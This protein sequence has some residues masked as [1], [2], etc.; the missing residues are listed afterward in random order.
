MLKKRI[1]SLVKVKYSKL[2]LGL[3]A[4]LLL[5]TYSYSTAQETHFE[6]FTVKNG[7]AGNNT[8]TVTQD[9]Q[10]FLWFVNS[11]KLHRFDGRNFLIYNPPDELEDAK[12][13]FLGL[14]SYQD[15]LL[16]VWNEKFAFLFN[17]RADIWSKVNIKNE[18]A[19]NDDTKFLLKFGNENIFLPREKIGFDEIKI[20][21]FQDNQLKSIPLPRHIRSL[22]SWNFWCDIDAFGTTHI[23]YQDTLYQFDHS[24]NK[25]GIIPL[26]NIC[27]DCNNLCFNF[28]Q[29]GTL[30]LMAN[31]KFFILDR[32]NNQFKPHPANR[33][34]KSEQTHLHRFILGKDGDIWACG[35]DR[36][37]IYYDAIADTLFNFHDQLIEFLPNANDFKGIFED[38]TGIIWVETRLGLLKVKHQDYPFY[39]YFSGLNQFN[40]YYSFRGITED[41]QDKIYSV[42]YDGIV[43][44]DPDN[45]KDQQI[46][47]LNKYPESFDLYADENKIWVNGGRYLDLKTGLLKD[48]PSPF[49]DN[50]VGDN[51]YFAKDTQ[52]TLWWASHYLLLYLN[53]SDNGY[54]WTKAMEMPER[55]FH[56]TEALHAGRQSKKLWISFKGKLLQYDPKTKSQVWYTPKDWGLSISRILAIEENDAG[57]LWLATDAGLVYFNPANDTTKHFTVKDGL[58]NNFVCGLL[59][60]GDSC[61]WLSTNN[62][63][64]RFHI[65]SKTFVNFYKDDGLTNNEFNRMSYFKARNG[66]M[67]FG[68][69]SGINS[70]FPDKVMQAYQNKNQSSKLV[71][72]A[73]EY[74]DEKR[75]TTIKKTLFGTIPLIELNHFDWSYTF[76]FALTDYNNPEETL[77]SYQMEG[78]KNTWSVP[79][80]FNFAR[81]N[82][83]PAGDYIFRVKARESTGNWSPN[84]LSVR[85]I[86]HSPWWQTWW[87]YAL[88]SIFLVIIIYFL[89]RY[90]VNRQKLKY[91]LKLG[92]VEAER[93]KELDSFKSRLYTNLTHEFRT[94]LTVIIGMAGHIKDESARLIEEN[95]KTL[96]QLINQLLDLS[97]LE[98]KSFKIDMKQGEIISYLRYLTESFQTYANSKNLSLRFFSPVESFVM[99]YDQEL[100]KHILINLISNAIKYTPSEGEVT[101]RVGQ[102]DD[103]LVIEMS[104]TGIGIAEKDL[105]HIFDRFYQVDSS[106]TRLG[107]GTGIGLAHTYELIKVMGGEI[108]VKSSL[109]KGST[110]IV[111]LSVKNEAP[112]Q[113][114][115]F[116]VGNTAL[117]F[118]TLFA[119]NS[120]LLDTEPQSGTNSILPQLL[121]IE[122]N[123]DVVAYLRSILGNLFQLDIAY[124]GKIGIE[125]AL[126]NIPDMIISD[127]MMP[128]KDGYEVCDTL[129]NDEKTSHIPIILLTA[130]ADAASRIAGLRRGADVYLSKPF[131]KEELLVQLS[132]LMERQK[133][134]VAWFS[135]KST[136]VTPE[137]SNGKETEVLPIL[138]NDGAIRVENAFLKKLEDIIEANYA[139]ENFALPQMC[140]KIGM[141]RS[142]LFRKMKAVVNSSPSDFLRS[143]RLEKAKFLLE[144][145]DLN[146]SEVT[147]RIGYKDISHFSRSYQEKFGFLPS[148]TKR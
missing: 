91:N 27:T 5:L 37:L 4:A 90:E 25:I 145:T 59:T 136:E 26:G 35:L 105:P 39:S 47:R 87:A 89:Q 138:E 68:G 112:L 126:E 3:L 17:T 133:R 129:K 67:F 61:L 51:G 50:P 108:S 43:K 118:K 9:G 21:H 137:I 48:V 70:F 30:V 78:Y 120:I 88:Y 72:S 83:L 115:I 64:S 13:P 65:P 142:Q 84:E 11:G 132:R 58:A 1:N 101:V 122:D 143:F 36:N 117:P 32:I 77:Y 33:F 8:S 109:G 40:A 46:L 23:A 62:G 124:N 28:G 45:K 130:K 52:G 92:A 148:E 80:K 12:D 44:F 34:L 147:Y 79:S 86:I 81:F 38:N 7:L 69:V 141:S 139:D 42:F 135:R 94:P 131:D 55:V 2:T 102:H 114:S 24:G 111:K 95:G 41:Q 144:T 123:P 113:D 22:N 18:H 74:I 73:F 63:L 100:I 60:E 66:R 6:F 56:K 97:K 10:G 14:A 29:D 85:V 71:L 93:L 96:L 20:L 49:F 121:I 57:N 128:E 31:W 116:E 106:L 82:S 103:K 140:Q 110:F 16:L 104:D 75:D 99:D 54:I 76:E 134:M 119:E 107:E 125:K 146:I 19:Q 15:S 98:N 53:K 127:V